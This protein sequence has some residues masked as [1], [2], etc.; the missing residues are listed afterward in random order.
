[1]NKQY[2]QL[3]NR[4]SELEQQY[5]LVESEIVRTIIKRE[6]HKTGCQIN[7]MERTVTYFHAHHDFFATTH[8]LKPTLLPRPA[9]RIIPHVSPDDRLREYTGVNVSK[10]YWMLPVAV[11]LSMLAILFVLVHSGYLRI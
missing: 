11:V 9:E 7:S 6:L 1:M 2:D 8:T 10:Y 5:D 3:T 4:R